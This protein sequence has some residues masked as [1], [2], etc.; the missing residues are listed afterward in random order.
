MKPKISI[1]LITLGLTFPAPVAAID[2]LQCEAM[3]RVMVGATHNVWQSERRW[4]N[5]VTAA[6]CPLKASN[7]LTQ[8]RVG[9]HWQ[10]QGWGR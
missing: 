4:R 10:L 6:A 9:L 1:S 7:D 5:R 8:I 3:A 2:Y